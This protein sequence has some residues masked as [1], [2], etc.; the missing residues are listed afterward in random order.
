MIS[1]VLPFASWSA[2]CHSSRW[3]TRDRSGVSDTSPADARVHVPAA[4]VQLLPVPVRVVDL[5]R[6][7]APATP[8]AAA[9][10]TARARS[11]TSASTRSTRRSPSS[12]SPPRCGRARGPAPSRPLR[13]PTSPRTS[14]GMCWRTQHSASPSGRRTVIRSSATSSTRPLTSRA[15]RS[16]SPSIT[17]AHEI[18]H[19]RKRSLTSGSTS[20]S[21]VSCASGSTSGPASTRHSNSSFGSG[22]GEG[23]VACGSS[24]KARSSPRRRTR[25][26]TSLQSRLR[27][28][29]ATSPIERNP[30]G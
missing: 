14:G 25:L 21:T 4:L 13:V 28:A 23:L 26:A 10:R 8:R 9:S 27:S 12:R 2:I 22:G 3:S 17:A 19:M 11:G 1:T 6:A 24:T 5:D 7:D 20:N 15:G 16:A 30:R 29:T 18:R